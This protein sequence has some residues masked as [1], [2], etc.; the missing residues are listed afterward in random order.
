[1]ILDSTA[2]LM[3]LFNFVEQALWRRCGAYVEQGACQMQV[4]KLKSLKHAS[5][6]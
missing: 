4:T 1:M 6:R 5:V 2:S 3:D